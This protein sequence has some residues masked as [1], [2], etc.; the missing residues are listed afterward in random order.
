MSAYNTKFQRIVQRQKS[1]VKPR[2]QSVADGTRTDRQPRLSAN[3]GDHGGTSI[4]D[5]HTAAG[6][7][8]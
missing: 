3:T 2:I 6:T 4:L 5:G 8:F 1:A 7:C